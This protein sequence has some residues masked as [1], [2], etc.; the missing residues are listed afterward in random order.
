MRVFRRRHSFGCV[1]L[2]ALALQAALALAYT[3]VHTYTVAASADLAQRAITYG[4]CRAGSERPCPPQVP[5]D[6]HAKCSLCWSMSLAS[7]AVLHAPPPI[8]LLH[9]R[10]GMLAPARLAA[11]VHS[12]SSV[13]FQARAPPHA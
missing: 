3:H 1:A 11:S 12:V 5:H 8:P 6:D 13:H 2:L 9:P 7:A 10:I 4:M